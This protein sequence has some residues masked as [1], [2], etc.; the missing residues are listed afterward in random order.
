[1]SHDLEGMNYRFKSY[2][3]FF[4]LRLYV[5]DHHTTTPT[6]TESVLPWK[7]EDDKGDDGVIQQTEFP[8]WANNKV[9]SKFLVLIVFKIQFIHY[10]L[11]LSCIQFS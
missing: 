3:Y 2:S 4:K 8:S 10:Y 9:I 11:G 5:G 6:A 1:M 7:R